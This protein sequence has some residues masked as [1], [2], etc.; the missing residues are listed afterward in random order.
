[1][2]NEKYN[3]L[4][5]VCALIEYIGRKTK[6][7]RSYVVEKLGIKGIE[8]QLKDAGVNHCLSF[9]Q[10]C[11]ELTERYGLMEGDFDTVSNCRYSV[12]DHVDIGKL[13]ATI[14]KDKEESGKEAESVK[15]VFSSFIS[16]MISDFNSDLYYQNPSYIEESYIAGELLD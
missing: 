2:S 1:M 14:I 7:H 3:D 4:F 9:E 6:N 12:P 5:Y 10:V 8:K 16:D 13:Y 11:D 15:K